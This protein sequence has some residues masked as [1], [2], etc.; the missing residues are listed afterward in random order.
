MQHYR[1][2]WKTAL[3]TG[4]FCLALA[5]PALGQGRPDIIWLRNVTVDRVNSVI[6]TPDGNKLI[7]GGSDRLIKFWSVQDG[8]LLQTLN[9]NAPFV[10]ESAIEWLSITRDG[11]LLA[12]CSYEL[13]QLWELPSGTERRL[14]GHT[15]WVVSVAFSPDGNTLASASFDGT[16]KLW[17]PSDGSLITTITAPGQQR[18]VAFSPDGSLLAAASGDNRIRLY[19]TSDWSLVHE[20]I[21]HLDDVFTC[22]FSPDGNTLASGGYDDTARLWNVADGTLKHTL[23]GNGGTVYSVAFTPD[24]SQLAY[25][26]GEGNTVKIYRTA[27]GSLVRTFTEE[28]NDVQTVSFSP[29]GLLGYGRI[30][31]TVVLTRITGAA[32][33][34]ITSPVSGTIFKSPANITINAVP[35]KNDGSITRMEFFQNGASLGED[36]TAPFTFNLADVPVGTYTLTVRDTDNLGATTSSGP[37]TIIVSDT[38]NALP[39]VAISSPSA[40]ASFSVGAKVNITASA[41]ADSGVSKVTFFVNGM[42]IGED[43]KTPFTMTWSSTDLGTFDLT[44]IVTDNLG[45]TGE[46]SLVAIN[47]TE[48][49]PESVKPRIRINS[50]AAGARVNTAD[51]IIKGTASDN[52]G[53]AAVLY[54]VNAGE[55]LTAAGTESWEASTTLSPGEN[56]VQVKSVDTSGNE[57]PITTRKF[58]YVV[59]SAIVLQVNGIGVVRS[60]RDGQ[61]LQ[62]GKKYSIKATPGRDQVF[63]GWTGTITTNSAA[64]SFLM[65]PGLTLVANF[66]PNPFAAVK[67]TYF[68]L[69]QP[70]TPSHEESGFFRILTTSSGAFSGKITMGGKNYSVR[71]KFNGDGSFSSFNPQTGRTLILQLDLVND[72]DKITGSLSDGFSTASLIGDRAVFSKNNPSIHARRY[73]V[74]IPPN[75]AEPNSP[76]GNGF[77]LLTVDATGKTR[78]AGTLADGTTFSQSASISKDGDWPFYVPTHK[79]SGSISGK[80]QFGDEPGISDLAGTVNWFR[81]ANASA[82]LFSNGFSAQTTLI[83]SGYSKPSGTRVLEVEEGENNVLVNLG[84]GDLE[85]EVQRPVTLGSNNQFKVNPP[86]DDKLRITV[87]AATG[88][89]RGSFIHPVT[90]RT[91]KHQG[92]IFQKQNLAQGFFLG[93]AQ[94]G[95]VAIVPNELGFAPVEGPV[96]E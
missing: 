10:H 4:S 36:L 88:S 34:R 96:I 64:F 30:D 9:T 58:T 59:S 22:I 47:I 13:I 35:S 92:V 17:R 20:L 15:D 79:G 83:G 78:I 68:G 53:V 28:V 65:E 85:T 23:S 31:E 89:L 45:V 48:A 43:T 60:L 16:V 91:T 72:T 33:P 1:K 71:G 40:G 38:T 84:S 90:G 61:I 39:S 70:E 76:H 77:G 21:G 50:P 19:R 94:A 25:T 54:S 41:S 75:S 74:L 44:A 63:N 6:F 12:S 7:S 81:S 82:K 29:D 5:T 3:A 57:S 27:D 46:S 67:G 32:S 49:P 8:T 93:S 51:V 66:V 73:T 14:T 86:A 55:F 62:V 69:I 37:I 42:N 80:V 87:S 18:C 11:S 26:D 52:L 24:G 56:I 2:F 95:F